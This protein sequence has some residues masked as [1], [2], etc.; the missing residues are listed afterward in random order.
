MLWD[1][2]YRNKPLPVQACSEAKIVF[3]LVFS[4][5]RYSEWGGSFQIYGF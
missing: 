2:P 1:F 5:D 4:Y 3:D